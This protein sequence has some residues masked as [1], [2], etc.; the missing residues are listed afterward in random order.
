MVSV[1]RQLPI[2]ATNTCQCFLTTYLT[3]PQ[4]QL[5]PLLYRSLPRC[6][7][8]EGRLFEARTEWRYQQKLLQL[9][10]TNERQLP[11]KVS[12]VLVRKGQKYGLSLSLFWSRRRIYQLPSHQA[13]FHTCNRPIRVFGRS[14]LW[15]C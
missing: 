4:L 13:A 3:P 9:D 15:W 14:V 2:A 7:A 6:I 8:K 12:K 1:D 11:E 5:T 10:K